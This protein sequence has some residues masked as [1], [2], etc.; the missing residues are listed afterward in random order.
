M[1]SAAR[2]RRARR[3]SLCSMVLRL[4]AFVALN[5]AAARPIV[6]QS[7][8]VITGRVLMPDSSAASG[9]RV[10]VIGTRSRLAYSALTGADGRFRV[11][12]SVPSDEYVIRIVQPRARPTNKRVVNA[13]QSVLDVGDLR[14]E[15]PVAV[16]SPVQVRGRRLRPAPVTNQASGEQGEF[17]SS[18]DVHDY[19]ESE[20]DVHTLWALDPSASI[21]STPWGASQYSVGGVS[22]AENTIIIN[23]VERPSAVLPRGAVAGARLINGTADPAIGRTAGG[24]IVAVTPQPPSYLSSALRLTGDAPATALSV[25]R[26]SPLPQTGLTI[27][28]TVGGPLPYKGLAFFAAADGESRYGA[29]IADPVTEACTRSP[30]DQ[31]VLAALAN[32][33]AARGALYG[34]RPARSRATRFAAL[35][36]IAWMPDGTTSLRVDLDAHRLA[37][38]TL[39]FQPGASSSARTNSRATGGGITTSWSRSIGERT[40]VEVHAALTQENWGDSP[41]VAAPSVQ[42]LLPAGAA[43]VPFLV[44]G[45]A[46]IPS[47]RVRRSAWEGGTSVSWR[48]GERQIYSAG[49]NARR[50]ARAGSTLATA[51]GTFTFLSP[52]DLISGTAASYT[53]A[54]NPGLS[55]MRS[56]AYSGYISDRILPNRALG[57]EWGLRLDVE[58]VA[59]DNGPTA[60]AIAQTLGLS[61]AP[62]ISSSGFSPRAGLLWRYGSGRSGQPLGDVHITIGAFRGKLPAEQLGHSNVNSPGYLPPLECLNGAVPVVGGFTTAPSDGELEPC[63]AEMS[64]AAESSPNLNLLAGGFQPMTSFRNGITWASAFRDVRLIGSAAVTVSS[65]VA[66]TRDANFTGQSAFSLPTEAN[67]PVFIPVTSISPESGLNID[68]GSRRTSLANHVF[69]LESR[70]ALQSFTGSIGAAFRPSRFLP[71]PLRVTY[72]Y[73]NARSRSR[74]FVGSTAGSPDATEWVPSPFTHRHQILATTTL[75][76]NGL[77]HASLIARVMSGLPY[78]PLVGGDINGDGLTNDRAYIPAEFKTGSSGRSECVRRQAGKIAAPGS[79][80]TAW[81]VLADAQVALNADRLG[82]GGRTT[83]S[84]RLNNLAAAA[85]I[86]LH[87][88]H[89]HGWGSPAAPDAILLIPDAFDPV[90]RRYHYTQNS[91]FGSTAPSGG[92]LVNPFSIRLDVRIE[93]GPD[94]RKRDIDALLYGARSKHGVGVDTA[95]LRQKLVDRLPDP[96]RLLLN[97]MDKLA[98]SRDQIETL[99]GEDEA[100]LLDITPVYDGVIKLV[101][102][103]KFATSDFVREVNSAYAEVQRRQLKWGR[104]IEALLSPGQQDDAPLFVQHVMFDSPRDVEPLIR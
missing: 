19:I 96:F 46:D 13:G 26:Y 45:G 85:D 60:A 43:P 40:L 37:A 71:T 10:T 75:P 51:P 83:V 12:D 104:R 22:P 36:S 2:E 55:Q 14:L 70:G 53:R 97:A 16:L 81:T 23:G 65:T 77:F 101:M 99:R 63:K 8:L 69:E 76:Y 102:R 61:S 30:C 66:D 35:A 86:L 57:F 29:A 38:T 88:S 92:A 62:S 103:Q 31:G 18:A 4:I 100:Y 7:S 32:D 95:G 73:T 6:A 56:V 80:M 94:P 49:G 11:A 54:E 25:G 44:A 15:S 68:A 93:L 67:R 48:I 28:G 34:S 9:A 21:V 90:A 82:G 50:S 33:L 64:A 1:G 87:G 78:T 91:H 42:V 5:A 98:L 58:R 24:A 74:G 41:I 79:C 39:P 84:L 89:L 72:A 20:G 27:G 52:A 3:R 47:E 59:A 17:V